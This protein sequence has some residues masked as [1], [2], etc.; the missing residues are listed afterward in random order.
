MKAKRL[1]RVLLKTLGILVS[2]LLIIISA[3]V[4][5]A[6]LFYLS[7]TGGGLWGMFLG[8]C[9]FGL[10]A[11]TI[12]TVVVSAISLEEWLDEEDKEQGGQG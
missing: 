11:A 8:V 2:I 1:V 9:S 4:A 5:I 6:W 7:Q 3:A 12:L 10:L